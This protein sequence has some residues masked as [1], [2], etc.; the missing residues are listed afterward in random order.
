[1]VMRMF[2]RKLIESAYARASGW[3]EK[4]L[5]EVDLVLDLLEQGKIAAVS[6][7]EGAWRADADVKKAILVAFRTRPSSAQQFGF[8]FNDKFGVRSDFA[9]TGVRV[10]PGGSSVRR[11]AFLAAGV[12]VMPPSYV[13]VGAFVDSGTMIDSHV[14]VGSCAHIGKN[15]HLSA[16]VMVG[17]VLEPPQATPVVIE[18]GVF[19]GGNC[20]VYE[21][22]VV[23]RNAVIASGVVLNASVP[24]IDVQTGVEHFGE[25]PENAV[26]VPG[27]RKKTTQDGREYFVSTPLIVKHR[28]AKTDAKTALESALRI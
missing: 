22:M 8:A 17:G 4:E 13:N 20:G 23:R 2:D 19:V 10:V 5:A 1:M 28:D 16:G 9:Q 18:D 7:V 14:L 6:N 21:G 11:G 26:V 12:I 24:V 3:A 27:G 25:V 15:V